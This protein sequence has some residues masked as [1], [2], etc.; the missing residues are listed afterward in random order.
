MPLDPGV[1]AL[2]TNE[3]ARFWQGVRDLNPDTR[4]DWQAR[5]NQKQLQP[6]ETPTIT[7]PAWSD[8]IQLGARQQITREQTAEWY[9]AQRQ[10]RAPNLDAATVTA[11]QERSAYLDAMRTSGAPGYLKGWG[12]ILTALDNVQDLLSTISTLG[13]LTLWAAPRVAGRFV[14]VLGWVILAADLLNLLSLIGTMAT[15][16]YALLCHGPSEALAAGVPGFV[17]K[18]GLKAQ[19]WKSMLANPFS[20]KAIMASRLKA[21]GRLP[22]FSNLIEVAQVTQSMWGY[23]LSLGG[24]VGAFFETT[25][26]VERGLR[27]EPTKINN[28]LV[29]FLPKTIG[30]A[31]IGRQDAYDLVDLQRAAGVLAGAP[32]LL[33]VAEDLPDELV[34]QTLLAVAGAVPI[35]A[36]ALAGV[37]WRDAFAARAPGPWAP[38]IQ[39]GDFTA[40]YLEQRGLTALAPTAHAVPG[41]PETIDGDT[42]AAK[43]GAACSDTMTRWL[44]GRRNTAAG[45]LAGTLINQTCEHLWHF[46]SNDSRAIRWE[47][48]TDARLS[49]S[50]AEEGYLVN[51]GE[52]ERAIWR[53]WQAARVAIEDKNA[54]RLP[55]AKWLQL[56][57]AQGLTLI[58]LL[59]PDAPWPPEWDEFRDSGGALPLVSP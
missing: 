21:V 10:D 46:V 3:Y 44:R 17:F 37:E 51:T 30:A 14:P 58:K 57:A 59:P 53:F 27:G 47:L 34:L 8:V 5:F 26:A 2:L 16:A 15:P 25:Y 42:Y 48:S 32:K 45:V 6:G 31:A 52:P 19:T 28:N 41:N 56:A 9:A 40:G 36:D 13:R 1:S 39:T 35:L 4:A 55:A 50:L 11:I 7:L 12:E 23:G 54:T 18:R 38:V 24:L 29:P 49:A 33:Q 43:L 20:R 22:S